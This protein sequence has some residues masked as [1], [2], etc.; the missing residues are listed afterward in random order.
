MPVV[1]DET[2]RRLARAREVENCHPRPILQ[3]SAELIQTV[4]LSRLGT[5]YRC[6]SHYRLT[7]PALA[8]A[9]GDEVPAEATGCG[10]GADAGTAAG[11]GASARTMSMLP[12]K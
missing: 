3:R 9:A 1:G 5:G 7:S 11:L 2:H 12:L 10:L 6:L 8:A 4:T